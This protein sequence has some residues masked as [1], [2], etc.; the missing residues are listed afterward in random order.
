MSTTTSR[1]NVVLGGFGR[2]LNKVEQM[3]AHRSVVFGLASFDDHML[4]DIGLTRADV[5]AAL[6]EPRMT[7]ATLV[8]ASRAQEHRQH[9]RAL[10]RDTQLQLS[11]PEVL[12]RRVA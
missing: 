9:Q 11:E 12:D 6:V 3:R 1:W 10:A 7:D 4:R 5:D 2:I 8:L